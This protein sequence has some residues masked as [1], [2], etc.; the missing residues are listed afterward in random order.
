MAE[1]RRM[2][3]VG[4][5]PASDSFSPHTPTH[6]SSPRELLLLRLVSAHNVP[7]LDRFSQSDVYAVALLCENGKQV[8]NACWPV[9]PDTID[10]Y[11]DSCRSLGL[12]SKSAKL[13]IQFFDLDAA[14]P[15]DLTKKLTA[16]SPDFIGDVELGVEELPANGETVRIPLRTK[17]K[18]RISGPAYCVL[19]R[20]PP[21]AYTAPM[22]KTLFLVRHG[23]SV[24]NEAQDDKDVLTMLSDVD[25]HLNLLGRKQAERLA[26]HLMSEFSIDDG[27]KSGIAGVQAVMCS[28]LTRAVQTCM[29]GLRPLLVAGPAGSDHPQIQ[30]V[31]LN[32]NL[33]EKRNL[34]GKDSSGKYIGDRLAEAIRESL[35]TLY[36]DD[37]IAAEGLKDIELDLRLV[38]DR[39]WIGQKESDDALVGRIEDLMAQIRYS[40]HTSIAFVGHSHFFRFLFQR[41][42]AATADVLNSDGSPADAKDFLSQKLSN[43]GAV[44]CQLNFDGE[45]ASI[46]STQL[47]F[48]TSLVD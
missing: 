40:P 8:A 9:K 15:F 44:R 25:H 42:L 41:Y 46:T 2:G 45:A 19:G 24:W 5:K 33:R 26:A 47:L 27:A 36:S 12:A 32:P 3:C 35:R 43:G 4:S 1:W 29:I 28:P 34:M 11:W 7:S 17:H 23:E 14:H 31:E 37:P 39:W 13:V 10:P 16:S 48:D 6:D 30:M 18:S 38:R 22:T 21:E 20:A